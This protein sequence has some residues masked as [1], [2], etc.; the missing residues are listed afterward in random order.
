MIQ[1]C[2]YRELVDQCAAQYYTLFF[3]RSDRGHGD[4]WLIHFSQNPRARDV[5]TQI[6]WQHNNHFIH[7]GGAGLDMFRVIGYVSKNDARLAGHQPSLFKFDDDA[8]RAS[9]DLLVSQIAPMIYANDDGMTFAKLFSTTCNLSPAS[10]DIYRSAVNALRDLREIEVV[11]ATTGKP[12]QA[13]IKDGDR[14]VVPSQRNL[15]LSI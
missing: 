3:I 5:M 15:I 1:A 6:H 11:S 14:L 8:K 7:Y 2:L 4:Y 12:T 13:R 10:A 9:T